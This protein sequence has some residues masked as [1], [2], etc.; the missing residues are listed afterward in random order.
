VKNVIIIIL[1]GLM[2]FGWFYLQPP[3]ESPEVT[4]VPG[5]AVAP[6]APVKVT[7]TSKA[8]KSPSQLLDEG[9]YKDALLKLEAVSAEA[10]NRDWTVMHIRALDGLGRR[11]EGLK[12]LA[13]VIE[14]SSGAQ[15]SNLR[16][17]QANMLIDE[18]KKDQAGEVLYK[19]FMEDASS[20]EAQ[21]AVYKLKELWK[22]WLDSRDRDADL[23]RYN[24]VLSF[25]L[26]KAVDDGVLEE[27]YALLTKM[28]GRIFFGPKAVEGIVSFHT[29]KYGENLSS[30]AKLYEVAPA[31]I[32][33][34]NGLKSWNEIRANQHLR[35]IK[36]NVRV[37]V[38]KRRFN[39]DVYLSGLFFKRYTIG[40]GKAG[41]TP[42]VITTVSRSMARN[43]PYT[44]P[45]TGELIGPDDVR[46]PIGTR[47]IGLDIGRG[48]GIHGTR[49]PDSIGKDSSNGC[50]RML[51]ESVEEVYDYVMVGDEVEIR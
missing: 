3:S 41:N 30:I 32:A 44:S 38:E 14:K 46:N 49:E 50:I 15:V 7:T 21:E 17:L 34:I 9:L 26:Q 48:Y 36:G 23:V 28:N 39:M 29:V 33:Q 24:R 2:G 40:I 11:E 18:G 16:L 35:V 19:I 8:E 13:E 45:D 1:L 47:W 12:E 25:L 6:P 42:S 5:S 22:P 31:R 51:N 4:P 20:S 43:P 37:I 27:C 10:K